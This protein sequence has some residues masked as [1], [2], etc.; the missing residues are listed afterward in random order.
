MLRDAFPDVDGLLLRFGAFEEPRVSPAIVDVRTGLAAGCGVHVDDDVE[1]GV[2][3]PTD[4]SVEKSEAFIVAGSE[5]SVVDGDADGV[6]S[7]AGQELDVGPG[8]VKVTVFM[9]EFGGV[10][11]ADQLVDQSLDFPPGLRAFFET[12]HVAFRNHPVAKAGAAEV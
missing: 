10:G 8:D 1:P 3:R 11:W 5:E 9:P 4:H 7:G 6:V 12:E 2:L